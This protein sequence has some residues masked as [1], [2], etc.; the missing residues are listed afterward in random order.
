MGVSN[1]KALS[2][3][4]LI[5]WVGGCLHTR[6]GCT[7]TFNCVIIIYINVPEQPEDLV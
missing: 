4:I 2:G 5:F 1:C 3:K 6:G 7:W